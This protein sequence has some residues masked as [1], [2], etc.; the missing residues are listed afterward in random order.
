[1]IEFLSFKPL[2][3]IAVLI[4]LGLVLRVTLVDRPKWLLRAAFACRLL[5]LLLLLFGLCRPY[6]KLQSDDLHVAFLID[7][8]ESVDPDQLRAA[9]AACESGI[10]QFDSGDSYGLFVFANGLRETSPE[11]LESFIVE[12]EQGTADAGFRNATRLG[13]ALLTSRLSFPSDKARRVVVF[14]DGSDNGIE[15]GAAIEQLQHASIDLRYQS[16]EPLKMPEAALITF[17]PATQFAFEGE[18][19][20]MRAVMRANETMAARLRILHQGVVVAEQPISLTKDEDTVAFADV[21]MVSSGASQWSAEL[22]PERDHFP[23]NNQ[24]QTTVEVK[25]QP[26]VLVIH[27]DT[28]KLRSFGRAMK[29]QGIDLDIRG[30]R[31]LPDTLEGMLAFDAIILSDVPATDLRTLQLQYLKRYVAEFGGGLAMMG[32]ENSFGL[33]GYYRT[34]VEEVLPLTSRF[35]KEKQKPSLAMALVIDKSGSMNGVPIELARQAAKSTL[36]LLG[37]NDQIAVIGFDS[38][39]VVICDMTPAGNKSQ[40]SSAIDSLAAGGGTNLYPGMELGNEMLQRSSSRIKHMIIL[41][42]GQTGGS[43]YQALAQEMAGRGVTIS[44]VALGQGAARQLMSELAQIGKGRYYETNDPATVPQIFTKETMQASKSAIKEDV[45]G[46]IQVGE[47]PIMSGYEQSN[48]PVILGYV[49]TRANPSAQVLMVAETGDP[50]LAVT[51]YGLGMGLAYTSDLT[52]RWGSEWLAWSGGSKFWAQVI[53]GILKKDPGTG[54]SVQMVDSGDRLSF[55]ILRQ[56]N[57]MRPVNQLNWSAEAVDEAGQTHT[58]DIEQSG[59][60]RYRGE[61]ITDG[62]SRLTINLRDEEFGQNRVLRWQRSYP[63]EYRLGGAEATELSELPNYVA[64]ELRADIT[65][66]PTRANA[67]PAFAL[68]AIALCMLGIF[69][70]RI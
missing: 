51:R 59:L 20:R 14:S 18:I 12:C 43:N 63:A 53:R 70:R 13:D 5:G 30:A 7:A 57:A 35:E 34:P 61:L 28:R 4:A 31:G 36:E 68:L 2:L 9:L 17:E 54:M 22:V 19:V 46:S 27:S 55:D 26:R 21:E 62:L 69:L 3:L 48:L 45:Y 33:G 67:L 23:I 58:V 60:G 10:E 42:D 8:S 44:T 1:M 56:D 37:S 64:E 38:N 39:A 66:Q 16:I 25:G 15:L 49:M 29:R 6:W 65:P 11:A 52:E 41:S 40:V 47:H 50:L 24:M 32:S